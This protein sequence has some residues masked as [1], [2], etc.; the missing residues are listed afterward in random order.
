MFNFS[1]ALFFISFFV[2]SLAFAQGGDLLMQ[3]YSRGPGL[4]NSYSKW[5]LY[6]GAEINRINTDLSTTSPTIT[7]GGLVHVEYR[8]SQTVG[9]LSGVNYTP[10]SYTYP[11]SDSLGKDRLKYISIPLF[12]RVHPTKKVSLSMGAQ[13]NHFQ[14]G[15]KIVSWEDTKM[16][17]RYEEAIFSNSFGFIVQA[18]Y[19]F[20][21]QFYGYVNYRWV[22]K[23][24]PLI[25][26][27]T[28]N[29]KGV[30]LGL[31]YTFWKSFKRQ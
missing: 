25:Q 3:Q 21:Q 30:Q 22:K 11:L 13:Y 6:G 9:L 27:Q 26:K 8:F 20:W 4:G 19:H 1:K 10:I 2:S 18:G 15:E 28:N 31:T 7:L 14:K 17:A 29:T 16:S 12:L 5:S 24:S 23:T